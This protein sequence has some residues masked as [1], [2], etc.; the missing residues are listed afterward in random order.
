[1]VQLASKARANNMTLHQIVHEIIKVKGRLLENRTIEYVNMC[2]EGQLRNEKFSVVFESIYLDLEE[3]TTTITD[4]DIKSGIML[5]SVVVYCS[6]PV[7]L[8]QFLNSLL[9][10]Q[11]L[12]TIIKAT[13]NTIQSDNIKESLSKEQMNQFYLTLDKIFDFQFGKIL[14]AIS[15]PPE[16]EAMMAKNWPY[17]THFS[18]DIY[19]CL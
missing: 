17:F 4:E 18:Q 19:Q 1:M 13:V 15:S 7:A 11:S 12:R 8:S 2:T 3:V 9:S 6:E 14:L 16:I 10:T 5:F